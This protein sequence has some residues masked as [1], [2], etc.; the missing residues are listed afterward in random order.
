MLLPKD[1]SSWVYIE[2]ITE[3]SGA[4]GV[5]PQEHREGKAVREGFPEV[6]ALN[7][8]AAQAQNPGVVLAS[9]L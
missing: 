4:P 6:A 7:L 8:H 2:D 9:L 1:S 5:S 3:H